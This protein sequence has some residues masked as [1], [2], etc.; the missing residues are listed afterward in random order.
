MP[1]GTTVGYFSENDKSERCDQKS[2][3]FIFGS[4]F[5]RASTYLN[6]NR[7]NSRNQ[8]IAGNPT[9]KSEVIL[10]RE[11]SSYQ[12][13]DTVP[14]LIGESGVYVQEWTGKRNSMG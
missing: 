2:L 1:E 7:L 12:G 11:E 9:G 8:T 6:R 14:A 4:S 13:P 5:E 3:L 10:T